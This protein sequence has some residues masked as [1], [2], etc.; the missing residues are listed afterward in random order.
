M[1]E[2]SKFD[3]IVS[4]VVY[5][6]DIGKLKQTLNSL[7][8][9]DLNLM[10]YIV[11]NSPTPW[12][13][14]VYENPRNNLC[15]LFNAGRNIGFGRAHNINIR[16]HVDNSKY[17]LILNPDIYFDPSILEAMI[18]RMDADKEIGLSIPKICYPNGEIQH[19]NRR[20]PRPQDY[21][22]SFI[23]TKT[24][25]RLFW[26]KK[27]RQYLLQ[28]MN[29]E[30]PL[31]CPVISGCFM[32]FRSKCLKELGGFD[33]RF[34]LYLEDTDL[35]RRAFLK[36]KTVIFSD[37]L[38]YH[39]WKRGGHKSVKLFLTQARNT[40]RYFNKWGWLTD[41]QRSQ[42]NKKVCYYNSKNVLKSSS[43]NT[44]SE[45]KNTVEL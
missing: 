21:L 36:Y 27:Y 15:Y 33:E 12:P 28:D 24:R 32:F 45:K 42:C 34:F 18:E 30:K 7:F 9:C 16:K 8:N 14:A 31:T 13:P 1:L 19:V 41:I 22:F 43:V 39:H 6:P 11:D 20:L 23:N 37:L 5:K 10:I 17:F 26:S 40:L 29:L 25:R 44:Q 38:A 4:I 2:A 3:L 35:S